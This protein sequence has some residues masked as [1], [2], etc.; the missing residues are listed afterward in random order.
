MAH[1]YFNDSD[2]PKIYGTRTTK[3]KTSKKRKVNV[4]N[5]GKRVK[6]LRSKMKSARTSGFV[7]KLGGMNERTSDPFGR[8]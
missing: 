3:R 5:A 1:P 8:R 4:K 6:K 2:T 7:S